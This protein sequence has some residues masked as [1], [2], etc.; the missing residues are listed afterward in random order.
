MRVRAVSTLSIGAAYAC[1]GEPQLLRSWSITLTNTGA[2]GKRAIQSCPECVPHSL[3]ACIALARPTPV[4]SRVAQA[5]ATALDAPQKKQNPTAQNRG[6]R[7]NKFATTSIFRSCSATAS[8]ETERARPET[9]SVATSRYRYM[10]MA[11]SFASR[12][13]RA[14]PR[15]RSRKIGESRRRVRSIYVKYL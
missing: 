9:E 13:S 7:P 10:L 5:V 14:H 8:R 12:Y 1:W 11:F 15:G 3:V 2:M 4:A 6:A